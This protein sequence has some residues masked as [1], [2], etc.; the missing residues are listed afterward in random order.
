LARRTDRIARS[1]RHELGIESG[2][3][4]DAE[5]EASRIVLTPRK[6]APAKARIVYDSVTGL[7]ALDAGPDAPVLTHDQ[8]KEM[9][10]EFP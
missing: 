9:L 3:P 8:V 2:D 1:I 5:V 10:A 6:T 7:P 4:L